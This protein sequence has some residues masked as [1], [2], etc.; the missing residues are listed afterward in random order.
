MRLEVRNPIIYA[1]LTAGLFGL[2]APLSKLFLEGSSP[3]FLSAILYLGSGIGL[4]IF[5]LTGRIFGSQRTHR[6]A[7]P[8]IN[9]FPWIFGVIV[10]GGFLA[11][12][13]FLIGLS[14]THAATASLLLDFEAVTTTI[15]A[16]MLFHEEVGR[17][18]WAALL[19]ITWACILL[20]LNVSAIFGFSLAALGVLTACVFWS[21]DNNFARNVSAKDPLIVIALKGL[22]GGSLSLLVALLFQESLPGL[23]TIGAGMVLGFVSY[24]GLASVFFIRALR[25]IGT[26]RSA[27]FLAIAPLFGVPTAFILFRDLP[28]PIFFL[29]APIMALGVGLLITEHHEHPHHHPAEIHEHRHRHDDLHHLHTHTQDMPPLSPSGDHSHLH[30]HDAIT[31]EHPHRPDIH[32]RH[33]KE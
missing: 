20:T 3:L 21:M 1:L 17:R 7:P 12:L 31:H 16:M 27:S 28:S 11:P 18:A 22:C 14:Y 6:E 23:P 5:L 30:T 13:T 15:I 25:G 32:H 29:A 8:T 19:L 24:G 10:F 33:L 2:G 26:A 4:F 9:D